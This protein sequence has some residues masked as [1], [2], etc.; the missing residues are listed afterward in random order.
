M[1]RVE[2]SEGRGRG[3]FANRQFKAGEVIEDAPVIVLPPADLEALKRT[4]LYGYF[5][6]W[7]TPEGPGGAI[8]LGLGSIYNHSAE[9]NAKYIRV[10]EKNLLRFVALRTIFENEEIFTNYNGN[11]KDKSAL[12]F[13]SKS[14]EVENSSHAACIRSDF[15]N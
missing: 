4:Q 7:N 14:A 2:I 3:V 1:L 10:F 5:F 6:Q 15:K 11:P 12:W 13:E 8:C 9:P